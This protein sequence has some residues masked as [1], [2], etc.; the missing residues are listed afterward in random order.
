[1]PSP[2]PVPGDTDKRDVNTHNT[3]RRTSDFSIYL[4]LLFIS[5]ISL[6]SF[7]FSLL[8]FL[9]FVFAP[10]EFLRSLG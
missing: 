4:A 9:W 8:F 5:L 1:M 6:F 3:N 10:E 2:C 7:A